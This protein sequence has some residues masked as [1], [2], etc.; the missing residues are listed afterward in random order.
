MGSIKLLL[1]IVVLL[2]HLV[3]WLL[4]KVIALIFRVMG[5]GW[6]RSITTHTDYIQFVQFCLKRHRFFHIRPAKAALC[7]GA[8]LT[9]IK[10]R[11]LYAIY[12]QFYSEEIGEDA[13]D[14]ILSDMDASSCDGAMIVTNCTLSQEAW[15]L[16]AQNDIQVL[17]QLSPE[18]DRRPFTLEECINPK[19]TVAFAVGC[20]AFGV[21]FANLYPAHTMGLAAYLLMAFVC[22]LLSW[23][24]C[25]ALVWLVRRGLHA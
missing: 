2:L 16:A 22:L 23:A 3:F 17:E 8:D 12:C 14:E 4:G 20:V 6:R 11:K 19:N 5:L 7:P 10:D 25:T 21:L 18:T 9:A 13:V 1:K 24:L 15:E